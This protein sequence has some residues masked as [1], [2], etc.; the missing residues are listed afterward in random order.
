MIP[1]QGMHPKS[2]PVSSG[3]APLAHAGSS[4]YPSTPI[5]ADESNAR[6]FS[7][8]AGTIEGTTRSLRELTKCSGQGILKEEE[9]IG[10]NETA[11]KGGDN[12]AIDATKEKCLQG[13]M[14][15]PPGGKSSEALV[16]VEEFSKETGNSISI[17]VLHKHIYLDNQN[18]KLAELG[19]A[20]SSTTCNKQFHI[21]ILMLPLQVQKRVQYI[22][23]LFQKILKY[24]CRNNLNQ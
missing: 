9:A 5:C 15:D 19:V 4:Q 18:S 3:V 17:F 23:L 2:H 24:S 13:S 16:K 20:S 8:Q 7:E 6:S 21:V 12:V 1:N 14:K 10:H 22:M 11:V